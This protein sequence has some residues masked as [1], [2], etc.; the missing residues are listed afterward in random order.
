[1]T[2]RVAV[3]PIIQKGEV[4]LCH[5]RQNTGYMDGYWDLAGTGHVE[6]GE[7]PTDALV[8]EYQ[9]ELGIVVSKSDLVFKQLAYVKQAKLDYIYLYFL[10]TVYQGQPVIREADKCSVL[11]WFPLDSYTYS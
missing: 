2:I 3:I 7:S 9:E 4:V 5:R 6:A 8:R 10:V 11:G 1:M